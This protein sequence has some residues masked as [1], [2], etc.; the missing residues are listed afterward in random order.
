MLIAV[1]EQ[2]PVAIPVTA[3][4][5]ME[6]MSEQVGIPVVR[7]KTVLRSLLEVGRERPVQVHYDGF[8]SVVSLMQ[9]LVEEGLALQSVIDQF[10]SF[11]M[12]TELVSCPVR[13]K[14]RVMRRLMEDLKGQPLQLI[15][16]IKVLTDEGWALVLPDAERPQF[17]IVA[18]AGSKDAVHR[19]VTTYRD[20]IQS[21]QLA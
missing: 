2:A 15:D 20:K 14:G 12:V 10:P 5:V 11:H 6:E 13:A 16:G 21:F 1:K 7:T 17:K 19:L 18:Q 9:F 3:P 8:Y 4:S